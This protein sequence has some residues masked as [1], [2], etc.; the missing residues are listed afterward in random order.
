MIAQGVLGFQYQSEEEDVQ[1]LLDAWQGLSQDYSFN[2]SFLQ[3]L[4]ML[5][6]EVVDGRVDNLSEAI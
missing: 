5:D 2:D 4:I 3:I 1:G 6:F